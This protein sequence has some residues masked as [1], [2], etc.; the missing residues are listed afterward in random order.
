MSNDREFRIKRENCKETYLNG[1]TDAHELAVIFGV[2][3]I[4]VRKWVKSG[5]WDALYKEERKLD[6]DI[7]V[8]RKKALIQALRE[9]AKF[10]A[11][12]ALQSLVNLIKQDQKDSEP[13]K[14]LND[15]IV[16]F[17]DQSTDFM[18][19]KGYETLLK[20][21]QAI[22]LDLAEYLRQRNG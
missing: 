22:V 19:E 8:A 13:A 2:S 18:I 9:Y 4:T 14:E 20:Q 10:P 15:Y 1:N 17:M 3:E 5:N 7:K 12:T 6:N 16:R 11:D 21:Y